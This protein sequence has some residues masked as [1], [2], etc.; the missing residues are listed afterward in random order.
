MSNEICQKC[1]VDAEGDIRTLWMACLYEMNELDIPFEEVELAN[2]HYYTLKVCKECRADWMKSIKVW[3]ETQI[4][5]ETCDSGIYI[6]DLGHAKQVTLEE[7][8]NIRAKS[9]G[10][11]NGK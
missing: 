5:P 4:I 8:Q 2:R 9:E 7:F 3:F 10:E 1:G 11:D 6:R